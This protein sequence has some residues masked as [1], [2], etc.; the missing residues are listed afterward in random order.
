M[1]KPEKIHKLDIIDKKILAVLLKSGRIGMKELAE[2][3]N[4]HYPTVINR[5]N[6][7]IEIGVINK[8]YPVLQLPGIGIRKWMSLYLILKPMPDEKKNEF[9]KEFKKN[10]FLIQIMELEGQYSFTML[11]VCNYIKEAYETI[12]YIKQVCGDYLSDLNTKTTFTISNL[13]RQFFL[14]EEI[15]LDKKE[16]TTGF[17]PIINKT[18]LVH[19][20]THVKLNDKDIKL[21]NYLKLNARDTVEEIEEKTRI[22]RHVINYKIEK[23]LNDNLIT[24]FT[25]DINH[26]KLGYYQYILFLNMKG[27]VKKK[28]L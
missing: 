24:Y 21:L 28:K 25:I 19:L 15:N 11:L 13:N 27:D 9:V 7:L 22:K 12:N 10:P 18:K 5:V 3:I 8:F 2:V 23:Y 20:G 17:Q 1:E 26:S 14:D 6:K 16:I 4:N